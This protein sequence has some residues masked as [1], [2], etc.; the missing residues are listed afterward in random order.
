MRALQVAHQV[1]EGEAGVDDVLD[2]QHVA[3]LDRGV[4]VLEDADHARGVGLRAVAGDR[5]EVDLAGDVDVAHQVGE[6]E[7]G[8]LQHA[9]HDQVAALVV[10]R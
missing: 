10:A 7:H 9:D 5:H 4:E 2:D 3:A 1:L 8:A 6:E